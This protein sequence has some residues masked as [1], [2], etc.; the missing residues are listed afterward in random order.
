[1]L[2]N[3]NQPRYH[4]YHS[5][6]LHTPVNEVW[7]EMR[8]FTKTLKIAKQD[9]V[10]DINWCDLGSIEK[11]PS[12][13][14]FTI[15]PGNHLITEEVIARNEI[16]H[17]L[18][19]RT[20]GKALSMVDYVATFTFKPITEEPDKTFLEWV[21]D[22]S[23]KEEADASEFIS[24]YRSSREQQLANIKAHFARSK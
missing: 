22:F 3:T 15:Q 24:F 20:V 10:E 2:N 17:S 7:A 9:D 5:T 19:Y 16:E 13:L 6:V 18:T 4:F 1:M 23:L 11:I 14:K 21:G 12:L 8:D